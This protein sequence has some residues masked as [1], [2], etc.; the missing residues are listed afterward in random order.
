MPQ[1][2]IVHCAKKR[3][4]LIGG[5]DH[6]STDEMI[7]LPAAGPYTITLTL[8]GGD[9]CDP[10]RHEVAL[11]NTNALRPLEVTFVLA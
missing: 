5:E 11:V 10:I 8:E 1:F 4:V 2:L 3:R 6:G 7:E 9:T